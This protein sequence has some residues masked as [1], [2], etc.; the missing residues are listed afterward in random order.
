MSSLTPRQRTV[1][2]RELSALYRNRDGV[3][4]SLRQMIEGGAL[5]GKSSYLS[6]GDRRQYYL[7]CTDDAEDQPASSDFYPVTVS[8]ALWD[9]F[10]VTEPLPNA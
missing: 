7:K 9:S 1:A 8:K 2:E 10:A 3:V 4:R 5:F 6:S